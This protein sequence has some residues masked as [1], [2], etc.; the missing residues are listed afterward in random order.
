M[1]SWPPEKFERLVSTWD[2]ESRTK[3]ARP[4]RGK[5]ADAPRARVGVPSVGGQCARP[6][7]GS[8]PRPRGPGAAAVPGPTPRGPGSPRGRG[9]SGGLGRL[10]PDS[11]AAAAAAPRAPGPRFPLPGKE[12]LGV[13]LPARRGSSREAMGRGGADGRPSGA[14]RPRGPGRRAG[15]QGWRVRPALQFRRGRST[16][17]R[18]RAPL[19]LQHLHRLPDSPRRPPRAHFLLR[20]LAKPVLRAAASLPPSL[21]RRGPGRGAGRGPRGPGASAASAAGVLAASRPG[22][23]S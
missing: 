9:E 5:R 17:P 7:G 3:A 18:R 15:A 2:P 19:L 16:P 13:T 11:P 14:A 22:S 10:G 6:R 4:Q 20:Q 8:S 23:A 1:R 21:P 12:R